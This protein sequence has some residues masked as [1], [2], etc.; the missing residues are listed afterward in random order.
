M[1]LPFQ[2]SANS[3]VRYTALNTSPSTRESKLLITTSGKTRGGGAHRMKRQ[4]TLNNTAM[5]I[6][7]S[8][9]S[10]GP[11]A[12]PVLFA[13]GLSREYRT[14]YSVA[15]SANPMIAPVDGVFSFFVLVSVDVLRERT[16]TKVA[17]RVGK[18]C[19]RA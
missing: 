16:K 18:R 8:F 6:N 2:P 19:L 10:K 15:R 9:F 3:I 11:L 13:R 14:R 4:V 5:I 1:T 7:L 17:H 12:N